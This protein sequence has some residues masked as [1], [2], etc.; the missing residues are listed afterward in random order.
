MGRHWLGLQQGVVITQFQQ[1]LYPLPTALYGS[2]QRSRATLG[3][4]G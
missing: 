3:S 1:S 4:T 2:D